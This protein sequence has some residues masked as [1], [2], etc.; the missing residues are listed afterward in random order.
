MA[1][2]KYVELNGITYQVR[3]DRPLPWWAKGAKDVTPAKDAEPETKGAQAPANKSR[4]APRAKAVGAN[5]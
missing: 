5:G 4:R 1:D 3:A 2:F